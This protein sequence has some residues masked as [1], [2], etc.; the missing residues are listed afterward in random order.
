LSPGRD[1]DFRPLP[2]ESD[3][4]LVSSFVLDRISISFI[5]NIVANMV[6]RADDTGVP[7]AIRA[8]E[9]IFIGFD[10]V[11]DDLTSAMSTYR[12]KQMNGAFETVEDVSVA[13]RNNFERQVVIIAADFAACHKR[14]P[15]MGEPRV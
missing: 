14:A 3:C 5:C 2:D 6:D 8:A 11:S 12:R 10:T 4:L 15:R 9:K 13:R 7:R 1:A